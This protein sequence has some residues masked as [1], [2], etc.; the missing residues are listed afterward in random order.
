VIDDGVDYLHPALGGCFGPGCK[1]AVGYDLVGDDFDGSN[2]PS[3]DTDPLDNCS[4]DSHGT[5]VAGIVAADASN[6]SSGPYANPFPFTGVAPGVTIGAYRVFSCGDYSSFD[7]IVAAAYRAAA[8]GADVLNL[9][10]GGGPDYAD[11][12]FN[13]ALSRISAAGH[14]VVQS[15]GN[16]GEGG[17][18][19]S[20]STGSEVLS[21]ASIENIVYATTVIKVD[22]VL[23]PYLPGSAN[24]NFI[25]P[26][27][28]NIV[29]N[30][31]FLER[32]N[33]FF[34]L[35]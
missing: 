18:L 7:I 26:E 23:H 34:Y 11:S 13:T 9:S 29:I 24:N 3:P 20:S 30:G 32:I 12:Y 8:D 31:R 1:V 33:L 17:I 16:D 28:L 10:L 27:T 2:N 14:I 21:I 19:S 25:F 6:I 15:N 35:L 22:D 5:H 4:M